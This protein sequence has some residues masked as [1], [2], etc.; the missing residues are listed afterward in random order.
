[1]TVIQRWVDDGRVRER[2]AVGLYGRE[3]ERAAIG[4]LL[5][6]ARA[7]A[8]GAG[9]LVLRG[10]AGVGGLRLTQRHTSGFELARI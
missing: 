8:S 6:G 5:S 1:M 9:A 10:E 4:A 2:A 7:R 3:R